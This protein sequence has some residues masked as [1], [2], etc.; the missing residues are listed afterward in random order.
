MT[1][2][3]CCFHSASMS[4]MSILK[5]WR[6]GLGITQLRRILAQLRSL[7]CGARA[8]HGCSKHGIKIHLRAVACRSGAASVG[9]VVR[10]SWSTWQARN[11]RAVN[12][13]R[14]SLPIGASRGQSTGGGSARPRSRRADGTRC[15]SSSSSETRVLASTF[16]SPDCTG[17][18]FASAFA[19]TGV[20]RRSARRTFSS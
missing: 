8:L 12:S 2:S 14:K 6:E 3:L 4:L 18:S 13:L 16:A 5:G 7:L 17:R 20:W 10:I 19:S 11:C 15:W 9:C 1:L